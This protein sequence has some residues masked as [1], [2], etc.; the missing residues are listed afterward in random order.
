M[1]RPSYDSAVLGLRLLALLVQS[2]AAIHLYRIKL[3]ERYKILFAFLCIHFVQSLFLFVVPHFS[4]RPRNAYAWTYL[5]TEPFLDIV[6]V[7]LV[8]EVYSLFLQNY[9]GLQT[10]ARWIFYVAVPAS[11][12]ISLATVLPAWR[13]PTERVPVAFYVALVKRGVNFSLVIFILLFLAL[14]S[15]YPITMS[16]NLR[17]H[18]AVSTV[19]LLS[20]SLAYLM[21]NVMGD[22]ANHPVNIALLVI[23]VL[24]WSGWLVLLNP[25]GEFEKAVMHRKWSADEE[26]RL[27]NQLTTINSSLLRA[28]RK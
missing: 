7:L 27:V 26:E 5:L 12:L 8:L 11:I 15:S 1:V 19:F 23:T 25:A 24:S 22:A 2:A 10:V 14:L 13:S 18:V 28:T 21:R 4:Q 3:S 20:T 9:K 17:N 6:S 16:R